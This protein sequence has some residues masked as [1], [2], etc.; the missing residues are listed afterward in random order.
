VAKMATVDDLIRGIVALP[1]GEQA[2]V[3]RVVARHV[4]WRWLDE[5]L[6]DLVQELAD[7]NLIGEHCID[8][9]YR[10]A[11]QLASEFMSDE[12][13]MGLFL[14]AYFP[15]DKPRHIQCQRAALEEFARQLLVRLK[16]GEEAE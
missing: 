5:A 15:P 2:Y 10:R 1:V 4:A 7:N 9:A 12:G 3:A 6:G 14:F 8:E 11:E 16:G 13:D